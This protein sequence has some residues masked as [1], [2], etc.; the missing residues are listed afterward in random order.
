M[1]RRSLLKMLLGLAVTT[2]VSGVSENISLNGSSTAN[3]GQI[4]IPGVA[5][6]T[7]LNL[8]S[9]DVNGN[10]P[11]TGDTDTLTVAGTNAADRFEIN[12]NAAGTTASPILKLLDAAATMAELVLR[13]YTNFNTLNVLGLEGADVFNVHT[14]PTIGRKIYIDAGLPTGKMKQT[15][16][17]NVFYVGLRPKIVKSAAIQN[18]DSGLI[19][20]IYSTGVRDLIQYANVESVVITKE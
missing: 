1:N 7:F 9:F 2:S 14:G 16:L 3:A 6:L 13:N 4:V 10:S 11:A 19:D 15:D 5:K 8:E 18:P 17:L 20:L 12:L